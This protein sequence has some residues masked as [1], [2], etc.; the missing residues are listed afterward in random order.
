VTERVRPIAPDPAPR[1]GGRQWRVGYRRV[2]DIGCLVLLALVFSW[3]A[4]ICSQESAEDLV[5]V[6]NSITNP[7]AFFP[8]S[9][10]LGN[11]IGIASSGI[12]DPISNYHFQTA[13]RMIAAFVWP[14]LAFS[15]I[16]PAGERLLAT[17]AFQALALS[18]FSGIAIHV[19]YSSNHPY[20]LSLFLVF[21]A[22]A[23]GK[24]FV[25]AKSPNSYLLFGVA[26]VAAALSFWVNPGT[27]VL[28]ILVAS[29]Y[30]ALT[31]ISDKRLAPLVVNPRL[32]KLT[33]RRLADTLRPKSLRFLALAA[34]F[35]GVFGVAVLSSIMFAKVYPEWVRT[36]S[37]ATYFSPQFSASGLVQAFQNLLEN[38]GSWLLA[39]QLALYAIFL[40][41][42]PS[43]R[44][45]AFIQALAWS[46]AA[47]TGALLFTVAF[48]QLRHS[49][50]NA[51]HFRYFLYLPLTVMFLAVNAAFLICRHYF[52]LT[53]R[54]RGTVK[55]ASFGVVWT[56]VMGAFGLAAVGSFGSP[57]RRC[58]FGATN[59]LHATIGRLAVARN[60]FAILGSY[61]DVWPAVFH[62]WVAAGSRDLNHRVFPTGYRSEVFLPGILNSARERLLAN[63]S[64]SLLCVGQGKSGT[65]FGVI[66]CSSL[67]AW[68]QAWGVL[69]QVGDVDEKPVPD[70]PQLSEVT[71]SLPTAAVGTVWGFRSEDKPR[72]LDGGWAEPEPFGTWT[73]GRTAN[74]FFRFDCL[75][76]PRDVVIKF[77]LAQWV[78]GFIAE[79]LSAVVT[80]SVNGEDAAVWRFGNGG[81]NTFSREVI[82]KAGAMRCGRPN[83]L[84]FQIDRPHSPRELGFNPQDKRK[85]GIAV[86]SVAFEAVRDLTL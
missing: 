64:L 83:E 1:R 24:K 3:G 55:R 57:S 51:Y 27:F 85:L 52:P 2:V 23:S 37:S 25:G 31:M 72:F 73:E 48:S 76:S 32:A 35:L 70:Q 10:R 61:W 29:A 21:V 40:V 4:V 60:H 12:S 43:P 11:L 82:V 75:S 68:N 50:S 86:G 14:Y 6:L 5:V 8:G 7:T 19:L 45:P 33:S 42:L 13:L 56:L 79:P 47:V 28:L 59:S 80:V 49:A 77:D 66:D 69:P 46:L 78:G 63:G 44:R 65:E 26:T 22:V 39:I 15:L 36:F 74:M 53:L 16:L 18:Q 9:N 81:E 38:S 58:D 54:S 84:T 17:L 20:A 62:A 41:L 34:S 67:V 30:V 71:I